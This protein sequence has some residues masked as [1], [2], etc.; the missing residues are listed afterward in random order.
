MIVQNIKIFW[1]SIGIFMF[2]ALVSANGQ[3]HEHDTSHDDHHHSEHHYNHLGFFVGSTAQYL[4]GRQIFTLGAEFTRTF[5]WNHRLGFTAFAEG[6]FADNF[7]VL[8]GI[9]LIYKPIDNLILRTG[10]GIELV[11]NENDDLSAVVVMRTGVAYDIHFK[12]IT[13]TPS[14]DIDYVRY[15]PAMVIGLAIGKGF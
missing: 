4:Q 6:I 3:T 10:P 9:P 8:T 5:K 7:Q 14:F 11:R 13:I 15:H 12:K 1:I 2:I